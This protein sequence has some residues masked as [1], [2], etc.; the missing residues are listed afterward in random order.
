MTQ[1]LRGGGAAAFGR[2]A[3][4][5]STGRGGK[6]TGSR[7]RE[8]EEAALAALPVGKCSGNCRGEKRKEEAE[9]YLHVHEH[10][11]VHEHEHEH[12]CSVDEHARLWRRWVETVG[13][14]SGDG[15]C[16]R[17]GPRGEA[18]SAGRRCG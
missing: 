2:G 1:P 13:V 10:V 5:S 11:H 16:H 9:L 4:V 17:A 7:S 3:S 6:L 15:T 14:R 18:R 8:E 12:M